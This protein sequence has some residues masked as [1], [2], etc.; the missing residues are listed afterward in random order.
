MLSGSIFIPEP[1]YRL[2]SGGKDFLAGI[3][4]D[5][6]RGMSLVEGL[7]QFRSIADGRQIK[8]YVRTIRYLEVTGFTS[9]VII[10]V[11]EEISREP[12]RPKRI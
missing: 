6:S 3:A 4:H 12:Q 11:Q 10:R 1:F 9:Y 7:S 8:L 5:S 2:I